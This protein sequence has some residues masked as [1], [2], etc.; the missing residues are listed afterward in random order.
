MEF[1]V[2]VKPVPDVAKARYDPARRTM[3]REGVEL[4]ANPFDQRAL[5]VALGLRRAGETVNVLSMGPTEAAHPLREALAL[6]ADR[7]IL[8]S[9]PGLAGSDTL[10]TARVLARAL[11][12]VG[13]DLVLGGWWSTDSE[14]GQVGPEVA[15]LLGVPVV[16]GAR[17]LARDPAGDLL[18]A[19]GES[20]DGTRRY[21]FP[22]PAVVTVSEK[23]AKP[24]KVTPEQ[25]DAVAPGRVETWSIAT[26]GLEPGSVGAAASPTVVESLEN[27][28]P[29]RHPI[30]LAEGSVDARVARA[31]ERLRPLLGRPVRSVPPVPPLPSPL[32]DDREVLVLVTGPDGRCLPRAAAM[33]EE[34]RRA[35]P[36]HWPSPVWAGPAPGAA[37][38]ALLAASGGYRGH[39]VELPAGPVGSRTLAL[40]LDPLLSAQHRAAALVFPATPFGREVAGQVAARAGLGLTGDAVSVRTGDDGRLRWGKPSFGGGVVAW[41]SCR[42]RPDLVTLRVA[43]GP[44]GTGAAP[45]SGRVEWTR[46]TPALP[47]ER[48][49][50]LETIPEADDG[51]GDLASARVVVSVGTGLGGPEH[52]DALRPALAAWN[53]ALAAT[54]RVVDAGWVS[55][56][57]QVGL[58]GTSLSPDLA[59]LIGVGGSPNHLI[60]WRRAGAILAVDPRRDSA[61]FHGADVGIVG[62]WE[63]VLPVLTPAL[64]RLLRD[65]RGAPG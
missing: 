27:E 15:A 5:R 26:L 23:I 36:D 65:R 58:T 29:A 40:A 50:L 61:V 38:E 63:E 10:V 62:R 56:R 45:R 16:T 60:G 28:E 12:R 20:D 46:W 55:R 57:R 42:S 43:S 49:E 64:D 21:R 44:A 51:F 30:L 52:L 47:E 25:R 3:V 37:D 1:A 8:L 9:D 53:A 39:L 54:R 11:G 35:L 7:A 32:R 34:L 18:D 22:P 59:V 24:L 6:G 33:M 2:L 4:F 31:V 14:T 41:V 13:H 48:I 17:S 19:V